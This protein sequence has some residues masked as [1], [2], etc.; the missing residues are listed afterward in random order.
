[1]DVSLRQKPFKK[2]SIWMS[3]SD[4]QNSVKYSRLGASYVINFLKIKSSYIY[5]LCQQTN[6]ELFSFFTVSPFF[7][8]CNKY[9]CAYY[10]ILSTAFIVNCYLWAS[11][12]Q[13]SCI[14]K[15]LK[16]RKKRRVTKA[17][18]GLSFRI[19]WK[20]FCARLRK[21]TQPSFTCSMLTTEKLEQGVKSVH[22]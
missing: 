20:S 3:P 13:L 10:F 18:Q 11:I 12:R 2:D 5:S 1:M 14:W 15:L 22:S 9:F 17:V 6:F 21:Y 8:N 7:T 16:V 4:P 19:T